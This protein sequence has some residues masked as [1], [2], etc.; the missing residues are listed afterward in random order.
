MSIQKENKILSAHAIVGASWFMILLVLSGVFSLSLIAAHISFAL[1]LML[2]SV[3]AGGGTWLS[4]S[5]FARESRRQHL[6]RH[7]LQGAVLS[8]GAVPQLP[9]PERV[10]RA[11]DTSLASAVWW[12]GYQ[13]RHPRYAAA[14]RAAM[15]IM[16]AKPLLPASP[17]AGGHGGATLIAHSLNTAKTM[18]SMA[19]GWVYVGHKNKK[20]EISFGLMDAAM[21]GH[22]FHPDDPLLVLTAFCHDIG[23]VTCY[24][25]NNKTGRVTEVKK[26]H[27]IRGAE[28]LRTIPEV[29]A[30][31]Y[32][33]RTALLTA[34]EFHHHIGSLPRSTWIDD[35]V[36][37]L[38]ELL[39]AADIA[40]GRAEGR[41]ET[42]PI[43]VEVPSGVAAV[44]DAP[45]PFIPP[46]VEACSDNGDMPDAL[47]IAQSVLL[48][49]G[50]VNG[51]R[52]EDRIAWKHGDWLYIN[53]FKLRGAVANRTLNS[54]YA[55]LPHRGNMHP[56]TLELM[57]M[58]ATSGDL[59]VEHDG[60][61]YSPKR[62]IFNTVSAVP[63]KKEVETKFVIVANIRAF[64]G[65]EN[66]PDCKTRPAISACSWGETAALSGA[67]TTGQHNQ[68]VQPE[69]VQAE[70]VQIEDPVPVEPVQA[71]DPVEPASA[72]SSVALDSGP[73]ESIQ[74]VSSQADA[75][76]VLRK[77]AQTMA[78]PFRE[79]EVGGVDCYL[80]ERDLVDDIPG[81][82]VLPSMVGG[83]SG[84]SY[85]VVPL[86][87]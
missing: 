5:K 29:M 8:I 61:V 2:A 6:G 31:P 83:K 43:Q 49:Q 22:R 60:K 63:G 77:T 58:L 48:E 35:R 25:R 75:A 70:P 20:G 19:R 1:L 42:D 17:V 87:P 28:L 3:A 67:T 32:R 55:N 9:C 10:R 24:E 54:D 64:P 11:A 66:V 59:L 13:E 74:D 38:T 79:Q 30:L 81:V 7:T 69:P 56:F 72:D 14:L 86:L 57:G 34:I 84:K 52:A 45:L 68:S 85:V 71:S 65:M 80:F 39:I 76:E 47:T 62:A 27:D 26:L 41:G 46:P 78:R 73:A 16:A 50:R 82:D 53:D 21:K 15:E 36:R 40:T 4:V 33:D 12:V 18:I 37:S 23:K 51:S 44:E